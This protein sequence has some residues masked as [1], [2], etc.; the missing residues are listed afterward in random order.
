MEYRRI[1]EKYKRSKFLRN[2]EDYAFNRVYQWSDN[3]RIL[4]PWA[5]VPTSSSPQDNAE[6]HFRRSQSTTKELHDPTRQAGRWHCRNLQGPPGQSHHPFT[7][8]S[9]DVSVN[10]V[11][12]ISSTNLTPVEFSVLQ[13]GLS[14][15]PTP[16]L[17]TFTL[18]QEFQ[19]F[20]WSLRLKTHFA[21]MELHYLSHDH[22]TPQPLSSGFTQPKHIQQA[23]DT[24][25]STDFHNP[26]QSMG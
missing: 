17:N 11:N 22:T 19:R 20:Y 3:T 2:I 13:K 18:E 14:F 6:V 16:M 12:N 23:K 21:T 7:G 25:Y 8:R 4:T 26:C 1:R 15:C 9:L 5:L 10:L 24:S